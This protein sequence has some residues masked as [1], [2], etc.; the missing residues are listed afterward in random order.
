[1]MR[2][3]SDLKPYFDENTM[4]QKSHETPARR[5]TGKTLDSGW[6]VG[7]LIDRPPGSTG[8]HFSASYI[9]HSG[10]GRKAF[11]KAMDYTDA[12][13]S[14]NPA[15]VLQAMTSAYIFERDVLNKCRHRSLSRIVHILDA[16]T[17]RSEPS[18]DPSD[19]VE[20]LVFELADGDIR[21]FINVNRSFDLAW[22]LRL[23]HQITAALRQLHGVGI[24]H[25][26]VKPSNILFFQDDR[27][28]LADLGRAS[29]RHGGSP[30]DELDCAGDQTYTPPELLYGE[31]SR[32]WET[33]R[34]ACDMYLLGSIT[35]FFFTRVSMTHLLL[36]RLNKEHRPGIWQ[37][38]YRE[39]LPYIQHAFLEIIREI[40]VGI[41]KE[42]G[43][44]VTNI[45]KQLCNP[46]PELRGHPTNI[47]SG[48]GRY[49]IERYVSLFDRLAKKAEYSLKR[50]ILI[51]NS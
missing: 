21:S 9:A 26:D 33:R 5:L 28:K 39:I 43:D 7:E 2:S 49:S 20:Y 23:M 44:D 47:S 8:G 24:A 14:S 3:I 22:T 38:S 35:V 46:D 51:H 36:N 50:S 1:M 15:K 48:V 10:D 17:L 41:P 12:L 42:Y 27:T 11:L 29:D 30:H 25:Q 18:G 13:K 6:I 16:G 19:V 32:D 34:L 40:Q 4:I 37:K 31:V 45:V